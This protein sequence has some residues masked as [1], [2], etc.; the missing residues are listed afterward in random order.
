[1]R[2]FIVPMLTGMCLMFASAG[3]L[4]ADKSTPAPAAALVKKAVAYLKENGKDKALAEF[5]IPKGI[6][7]DR[8][9]ATS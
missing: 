1:M 8:D 5:N 4:A 7:L 2:K 9:L 3:A 6:F